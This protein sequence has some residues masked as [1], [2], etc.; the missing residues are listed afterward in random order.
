[1]LGVASKLMAGADMSG[2]QLDGAPNL[3]LGAVVNPSVEP[4]ELQMI[5]ML[6]KIEA[7]ALF[8]QTQVAF[9]I[10]P[11]NKLIE[12]LE[13]VNLRGRVKIIGGVFLLKSVKMLNLMK[14]IPGVNIPDEIGRR[15]E[16][17][18]NQLAEGVQI[19]AEL[20]SKLKLLLDGVHIMAI[21]SEELIPEILNKV[22]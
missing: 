3:C 7:G 2:N 1:L 6:K 21:N 8:F 4:I 14:K 15:I 18:D 22:K 12:Y 17:S 11:F 10:E 16:N 5:P 20:I 9:D 19:C 13:R